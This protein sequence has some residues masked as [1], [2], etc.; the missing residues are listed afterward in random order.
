[1]TEVAISKTVPFSAKLVVSLA[2]V[3]SSLFAVSETGSWQ[4]ISCDT[5]QVCCRASAVTDQVV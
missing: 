4:C 2:V 1:M 5:N 3:A